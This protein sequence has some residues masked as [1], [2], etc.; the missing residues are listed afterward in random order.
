MVS[1]DP[2]NMQAPGK[3]TG[4]IANDIQPQDNNG[5]AFK[6]IDPTEL[7]KLL[8]KGMGPKIQSIL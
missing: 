2:E 5:Q 1:A 4:G 3:D 6:M 7:K 8:T